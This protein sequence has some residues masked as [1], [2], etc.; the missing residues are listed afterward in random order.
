LGGE[1]VAFCFLIGP[2]FRAAAAAA[3]RARIAAMPL[4]RA[5]IPAASVPSA[6]RVSVQGCELDGDAPMQVEHLV[7]GADA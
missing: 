2:V 1:A 5:P 3:R 6:E 7:G 4:I